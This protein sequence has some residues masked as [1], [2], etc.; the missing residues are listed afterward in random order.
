MLCYQDYKPP[1]ALDIPVTM[2]ITLLKNSVN[3]YGVISSKGKHFITI[4]AVCY[5][6][7]TNLKFQNSQTHINSFWV[8]MNK[9]I[10]SLFLMQFYFV[11]EI[12]YYL[13]EFDHTMHK[14]L[15]VFIL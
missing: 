11:T 5:I 8:V 10:K 7:N 4:I 2:N 13:P 9:T 15:S 1:T 3:Q 14:N 6:V 12:W